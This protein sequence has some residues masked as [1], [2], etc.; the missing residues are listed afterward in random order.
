VVFVNERQD[1]DVQDEE[2]QENPSS[3]DEGQ[4]Q[5]ASGPV[6]FHGN[7]LLERDPALRPQVWQ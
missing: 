6:I 3:Q 4:E 2:E 1:E 5:Q 7:D